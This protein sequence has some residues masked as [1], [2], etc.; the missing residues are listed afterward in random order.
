MNNKLYKAN[1]TAGARQRAQHLLRELSRQIRES[2]WQTGEAL[3]SENALAEH[4]GVSRST[5]HNV[6]TQLAAQ[7]LIYRVRGVGA[8]VGSPSMAGHKALGLFLVIH[9]PKGVDAL[10]A[11]VRMGFEERIAQAGAATLALPHEEVA[12]LAATS[13]LLPLSGAFEYIGT[14]KTKPS[15]FINTKLLG[16]TP[17]VRYS[18]SPAADADTV[19][20]DNEDGGRQ[21]VRHLLEAG[22][23]HI[24]FAGPHHE[25]KAKSSF[26]WSRDRAT[27]W[28]EAL[29]TA[30][31]PPASEALLLPDHE[32]GLGH[33]A[34]QQLG[35]QLAARLDKRPSPTGIVAANDLVARGI[36]QRLWEM[37]RPMSQWPAIIGFDDSDT[38]VEFGL[39]SLRLPWDIIGTTAAELLLERANGTLNGPPVTRRVKMRLINRATTIHAWPNA[40]ESLFAGRAMPA[41]S[42]EIAV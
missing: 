23:T 24:A 36:I 14:C 1:Q 42:S 40:L 7:H 27:G 13:N 9:P 11:Q 8:F 5:A 32:P 3:P 30:G 28:R 25:R 16:N 21:A 33:E 26:A 17:S 39:T 6:L 29:T 10:P 22:H 4:Y 38:S 41:L 15:D 12:A 37:G 2:H 34:Q 19:A 20:F 18:E 31:Y 35:Y